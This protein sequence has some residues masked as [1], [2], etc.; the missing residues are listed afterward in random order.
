MD[1]VVNEA[2]SFT[3]GAQSRL[4]A[5]LSEMVDFTQHPV[6]IVDLYALADQRCFRSHLLF[7]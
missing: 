2:V 6:Q 5:M 1:S 7:L 4:R 3:S